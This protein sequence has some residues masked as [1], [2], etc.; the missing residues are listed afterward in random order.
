MSALKFEIITPGGRKAFAECESVNVY[1]R[2]NEKGEGGGSVGIR[3]GHMPAVIALG[4][5]EVCAF[6]N[7]KKVCSAT[8]RGGFALVRNNTVTVM[9]DDCKED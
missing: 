6:L 5:G 9:T 7:G 8:V 1:A 4:P 3:P 2:D